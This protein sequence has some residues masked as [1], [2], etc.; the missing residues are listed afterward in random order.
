MGFSKWILGFG[1]LILLP[2]E[3]NLK[4]F[5]WDS[6]QFLADLQRFLQPCMK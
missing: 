2:L 1:T 4:L 6:V 5:N 3:R